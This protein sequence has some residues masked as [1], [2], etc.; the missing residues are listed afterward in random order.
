MASVCSLPC[1]GFRKSFFFFYF[2]F[3]LF[4]LV[5]L[6]FLQMKAMLHTNPF[7]YA[8]PCAV[9][10][11]LGKRGPYCTVSLP[12]WCWGLPVGTELSNHSTES[13]PDIR[14]ENGD[15]VLSKAALGRPQ[16][17]VSQC[18]A[19]SRPGRTGCRER[20]RHQLVLRKTEHQLVQNS[21]VLR[22][23]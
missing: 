5:W 13:F 18:K 19:H 6:S 22:L 10:D 23:E 2:C 20:V 15:G 3:C 14:W 21:P 7:T 4:G 12:F 17:M 1:L 16:H 9:K 11:I 8:G